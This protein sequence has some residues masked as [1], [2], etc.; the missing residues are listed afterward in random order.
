MLSCKHLKDNIN[1]LYERL[2]FQVKR[3]MDYQI[4]Y[5]DY[6]KKYNYFKELIEWNKNELKEA[7]NR[8]WEVTREILIATEKLRRGIKKQINNKRE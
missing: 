8:P 6:E 3:F 4:S 2:D 1:A 5:E 7:E